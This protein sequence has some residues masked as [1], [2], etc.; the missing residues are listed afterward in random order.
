MVF[1]PSSIERVLRHLGFA[2]R[3]PER[4]PPRPVQVALP[5]W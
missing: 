4:A 3:P 2:Y 1:R 5:L